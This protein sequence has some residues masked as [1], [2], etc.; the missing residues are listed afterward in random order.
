MYYFTL[1]GTQYRHGHEFIEKGTKLKLA[2]E[3]DNKFDKEAIKVEI[4]PLGTVGYVANSPQTVIGDCYSAGRLYDK[5]GDTAGA[6]VVFI[7]EKGIVC[8]IDE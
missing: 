6:T 5:I 1:A 8:S 2:K 7:L 3:P 4:E